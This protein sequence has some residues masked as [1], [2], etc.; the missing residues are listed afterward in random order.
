MKYKSNL[1]IFHVKGSILM[2]KSNFFLTSFFLILFISL[3]IYA[4][5]SS[6]NNLEKNNT[7]AEVKD[8]EG[9]RADFK[10][11]TQDP[12]TKI[13]KFEMILKSNID[14]DRVEINWE[15]DGVSVFKD[16]GKKNL[17]TSIQG[18]KTY[19]IPIELIV[20]GSG[21]TELRGKAEAFKA[22]SSFLITVR[23]DFATNSNLEILPISQDYSTAKNVS[24]IKNIIVI[25][26]IV[27]II[28]FI[29]LIALKRFVKWLNKDDVK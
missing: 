22:D 21:I 23:K 14:S 24:L 26:V 19:D 13:V 20:A 27:G 6:Q 10:Q 2:F 3:P 15:V 11:N 12:D 1:S 29:G 4:Q 5:S 8:V 9:F 17:K 16:K 28:L 25:L 18:G 7:P